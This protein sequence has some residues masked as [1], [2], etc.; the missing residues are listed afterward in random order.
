MEEAAMRWKAFGIAVA[1][2]LALPFAALADNPPPSTTTSTTTA[3]TTSN[4]A[5]A[6]WFAGSVAS[7]S[8]GSIS[9]N[10]LW[11][12]KHDKDLNGKTVSVA[13]DSSTQID[14][15]KGK[16][17]IEQGDLVG[18]VATGTSPNSLTAN[19]I[20]VRCNCHFAAGTLDAISTSR[21][22]VNVERTGPYDGVLKGNEVTF[23]VGGATLPNLSIGDKVAIVFSASGFFRDPNFDWQTATF[24]VL[25]LRVVHDK[26]E[27]GTNP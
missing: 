1:V 9:V 25:H 10:V 23:D 7:A 21:L 8:S 3:P 15:G 2:V 6:H 17:S 13:I 19:R 24:T 12:G 27:A 16:S 4:R 20:H 26:G 5:H 11:T 14:Y 18:V 22:R